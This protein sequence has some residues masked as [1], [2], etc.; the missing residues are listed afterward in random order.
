M[1]RR[2]T[3]FVIPLLLLTSLYVLF[4][5]EE[6]DATDTAAA[7]RQAVPAP[8]PGGAGPELSQDPERSGAPVSTIDKVFGAVEETGSYYVQ[9][10]PVG[11]SVRSIRL[12]DQPATPANYK[13]DDRDLEATYEMVRTMPHAGGVVTSMSMTE[14]GQKRFGTSLDSAVWD[15]E[16]LRDGVRFTLRDETTG[17]I[18]E[19]IYRHEAG[20]RELQLELALAADPN[21]GENQGGLAPGADARFWLH[22]PSLVN[23]A[24]TFVL[25]NPAKAIGKMTGQEEVEAVYPD[26]NPNPA[27]WP[28]FAYSSG[29]DVKIDF[30][31]VTNRFF[32]AFLTPRDEDAANALHAVHMEKWP[33]VAA[34][35]DLKPFTV[36]VANYRIRLKVPAAGQRN[37]ANFRLYL[38]PKSAAVFDEDP[39]YGRYQPVMDND[40]VP[41]GCF[42]EIPGAKFMAKT[43]LNFLR[44][45]ESI[46]GSWGVAIIL[47]TLV[48]RGATVPLNFRMQKAMRAYGAKMM[49]LKPELDAIKTRNEND[50]KKMQQEMVAFQREHKLFP[51]LGGCLPLLITIPVF[52]G[53]FTAL[54]VCYELRCQPFVGWINDLSQPDRLLEFGIW[55]YE[56]NLLPILMVGLWLALQM[57]T[58][59]PTDPQQR[60]MMKIMR[61]MPLIFGVMLYKYASGLMVYMVTSSLFGLI[62]Q[63]VTK[64][65]LGPPPAVAGATMPTF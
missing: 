64:K 32:G 53:L 39:E 24:S 9:F 54:R 46:V 38:G 56:F 59:L 49:R 43:L 8:A 37:A 30:A 47:M 1:E 6:P 48:I 17:L 20:R 33:K 23:P 36:P 57:G 35:E 61:F 52:I 21:R 50:P 3:A 22:G 60:Q 40:L 51:P 58:P 5:A 14:D 7:A 16:E 25:G 42:C 31:G 34:E 29:P 10:D 2:L 63:R 27:S 12:L 26:S 18:L 13:F 41:I 62:E 45:L 15:A 44:F 28:K 55:P 65:I 4:F 11:A 19:K